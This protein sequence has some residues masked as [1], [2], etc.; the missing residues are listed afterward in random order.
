MESNNYFL[1]SAPLD[2]NVVLFCEM[3]EEMD[4]EKWNLQWCI[5]WLEAAVITHTRCWLMGMDG[6]SQLSIILPHNDM[7]RNRPDQN[8]PSLRYRLLGICKHT[9]RCTLSEYYYCNNY[10]CTEKHQWKRTTMKNKR[11]N[12]T[13]GSCTAQRKKKRRRDWQK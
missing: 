4:G 9:R 1:Q 5:Q 7:H 10:S 12:I 13:S 3:K 2:R 8:R 11:S 6:Y